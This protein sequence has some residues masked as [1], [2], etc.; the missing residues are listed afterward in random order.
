MTRRIRVWQDKNRNRR[1]FDGEQ[2]FDI[3]K[4]EVCVMIIG[5][6]FDAKVLAALGVS[7][8]DKPEEDK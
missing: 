8:E 7:S 2:W 5:S 4:G 1:A 6:D 3:Q